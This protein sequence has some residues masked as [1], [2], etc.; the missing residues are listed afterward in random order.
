LFLVPAVSAADNEKETMLVH[1][2]TGLER[3]DAQI[4]VAYN[5]I[6]TAL[7]EG[8]RVNVLVDADA[9]K[10]YRTGWRGKDFIEDYKLPDDLR[11]MLAGQFRIPKASV[12]RTYGE[13]LLLLKENGAE[14]YINTGMVILSKAG[15][16]ED[17]LKNISAKFF[18][19]VSLADIIRM[20][21]EAAYYMVY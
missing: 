19:P 4:C 21:K 10:T 13:Y 15:T 3:D 17:P 7:R 6:W 9:V 11:R 1:I 2:K 20:R 5:V 16:H 8:L 14:F 12:P 18:K